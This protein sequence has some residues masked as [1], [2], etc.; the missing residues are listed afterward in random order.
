MGPRARM[1]ERVEWMTFRGVRGVAHAYAHA[2][3][4]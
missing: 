1:D 3:V 4:S 2:H